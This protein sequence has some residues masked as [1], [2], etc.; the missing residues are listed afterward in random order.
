MIVIYRPG[1]TGEG[2]PCLDRR[3]LAPG[4]PIPAEAVWIDLLDPTRDED[5]LVEQ[6]LN[7]EVPTREDTDYIEPS[8]LIYAE[9]GA[10]FMTTRLLYKVDSDPE[11]TSVTFILKDGVAVTVRYGEPKAF[12]IFANRA[13]KPNG[14]GLT[15]EQVMAGLMDT[16]ID[17]AAEVL[18]Q[19][20]EN[21]DHISK[22]VFEHK[23]DP[24]KRN[25]EYEQILQR[26]GRYGDLIS[27]SRE[28]LL[29]IERVLL[30]LSVAYRATRVSVAL[31]EEVRTTLRD[32]QSLE[33]HASFQTN[34]IQFL[35]DA[36][37]GLVNIEQNNIIKLFSVMAVVFMPPTLIASIYG[38]NFK[39]MPELE[40]QL[41]YPMALSMMVFAAI[42]PYF[43]F[44]WKKW[45]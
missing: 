13:A 17:R 37:L 5:K 1:T 21:I 28:S 26:L 41:G 40:W 44:R 8:E 29:S 2:A 22:M 24:G 25:A 11:L 7:I 4:R 14:C 10:R 23:A 39:F 38:M 15:A 31:R 6:H 32:L 12:D 35:L 27:K 30:S 43:F 18:Q 20:A 16:I 9:D 45:L 19:V 3:I 36:T 42:A 33:E 34:K